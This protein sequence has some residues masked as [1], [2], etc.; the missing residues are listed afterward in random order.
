MT[1]NKT[2]T[3]SE[4]SPQSPLAQNT[5]WWESYLVRYLIGFIVGTSCVLVLAVSL[6]LFEAMLK[7]LG[8]HNPSN[9]KPDWTA[10]TILIAFLGIGFCYIAST[11]ITVLHAGRFKK[12]WHSGHSRH[13]WIAWIVI[14]IL[15][16]FGF[17]DQLGRHPVFEW[18]LFVAGAVA[19]CIDYSNNIKKS[20]EKRIDDEHPVR[21]AV[22]SFFAWTI[23]FW[24]GLGR[25]IGSFLGHISGDIALYWIAA[26]P[27]VWIGTGQYFVLFRLIKETDDFFNFYK[28]LFKARRME[29]AADVRDT[30][31]HL[32]EH[33]NSVF[34]VVVELGLMAFVLAFVKSLPPQVGT[35]AL[36]GYSLFEKYG[37]HILIFLVVWM[38]PTVF[39]WSRANALEN[40]FREDPETYL[41]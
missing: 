41:E 17:S 33:S 30:Y 5:R 31:T 7:H 29:H 39:M 26:L 25:V 13:F 9:P 6:N 32:R 27:V 12:G 34:I 2:Q 18:L 16:C 40:S 4:K 20:P 14:A 24:G 21:H 11:P 19:L 8:T 28:K 22:I 35:S 3:A 15:G 36:N 38:I 37:A 10:V 1:V 23:F